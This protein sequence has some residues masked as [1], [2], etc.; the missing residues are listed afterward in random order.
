M[1]LA[2]PCPPLYRAEVTERSNTHRP[3]RPR[4]LPPGVEDDGRNVPGFPARLAAMKL[5]DAV[6]RRG[7]SMD[8]VA[9]NAKRG[10]EP[11][12]RALAI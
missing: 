3:H 6:I 11:P 9:S 5:L 1:A 10:L 2:L 8:S 12:D 7:E 4:R